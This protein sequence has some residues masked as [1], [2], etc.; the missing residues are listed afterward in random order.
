[1]VSID[2]RRFWARVELERT[3]AAAAAPAPAAG[4]P[5]PRGAPVTVRVR[6]G[7]VEISTAAVLERPARVGEP[8]IA[9]LASGARLVRGTLVTPDLFI[10]GGAP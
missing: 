3:Q 10:V 4:P 2:A 5:L 7:A 6:R 8:A 1:M 9:R